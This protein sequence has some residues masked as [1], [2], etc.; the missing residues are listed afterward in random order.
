MLEMYDECHDL[1]NSDTALLYYEEGLGTD[2]YKVC[3]DFTQFGRKANATTWAQAKEA[4]SE[5]LQYYVDAFNLQIAE[6][7][8]E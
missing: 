4:S 5:R 7:T 2:L 3:Q 1:A 8:A 6:K